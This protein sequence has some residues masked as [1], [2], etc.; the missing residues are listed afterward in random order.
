MGRHWDWLQKR[1]RDSVHFQFLQS[2]L[3]LLCKILPNRTHF[4]VSQVTER[5]AF[6]TIKD[7]DKSDGG[8][9]RLDLENNLGSDS[10]NLT[11]TV[12]G[13]L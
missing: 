8:V 1:N 6:L 12:N 4:F 7:A 10:G 9:Y 11:F 5:H 2:M 13:K 3:L